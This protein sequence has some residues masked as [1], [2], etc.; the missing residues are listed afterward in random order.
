MYADMFDIR[1]KN[2]PSSGFIGAFYCDIHHNREICK[3][4][5]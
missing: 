2:V 1:I 4:C 3:V 5:K